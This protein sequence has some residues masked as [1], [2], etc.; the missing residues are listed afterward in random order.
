MTIPEGYLYIESDSFKSFAD[1]TSVSLPEGLA[2]IYIPASVDTIGILAIPKNEGL[3]IY[4]VAGSKAEWYA[5]G[6]GITFKQ[7]GSD[8]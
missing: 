7:W 5:N 8:T 1:L 3:T 6:E 2:S 4:G